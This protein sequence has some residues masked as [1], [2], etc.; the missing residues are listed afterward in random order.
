MYPTS[1]QHLFT[2]GPYTT[3]VESLSRG[4][5]YTTS[6]E[7]LSKGGVYST[8]LQYLCRGGGAHRLT[9][10]FIHWGGG[11]TTPHCNIYPEVGCRPP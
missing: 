4:G 8:P 7:Y 3:Q 9:G 2:G 6:V 5:M 11:G 1:V 10:V